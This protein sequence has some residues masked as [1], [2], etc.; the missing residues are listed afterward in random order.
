MND[1]R[2]QELKD[3]IEQRFGNFET[4]ITDDFLEDDLGHK[5]PQKNERLIFSS[6]LGK[7]MIE[8]VSHPK[9]IDRISHYHKGAGGSDIEYK[10]SE[11]EATHKISVYKNDEVTGEWEVFDLPPEKISF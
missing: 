11:D 5:I 1:E 7:I 10:V 6:P 4:K 9:I 3:K 8:R 2:W